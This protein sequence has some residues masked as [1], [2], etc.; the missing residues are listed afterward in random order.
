MES[1]INY[2]IETLV[3]K[4]SKGQSDF[5]TKI[6]RSPQTI[7]N[8]LNKGTKPGAEVLEAILKS[9]PQVD[10]LWLVCGIGEMQRNLS[11]TVDEK[12]IVQVL[13]KEIEVLI[14]N[15]ESLIKDKERLWNLVEHFGKKDESSKYVT[16]VVKLDLQ[17]YQ[18]QA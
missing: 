18:M 7:S 16:R 2:R 5:A 3:E 4:L 8:I 15:N 14:L 12:E 13:K 10:A 9:F 1:E 11:D 17:E 6:G